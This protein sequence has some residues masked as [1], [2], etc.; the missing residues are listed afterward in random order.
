MNLETQFLYFLIAEAFSYLTGQKYFKIEF[1]D[2][3][4][5]KSI[6]WRSA[7]FYY[8]RGLWRPHTRNCIIMQE[9]INRFP[10][11]LIVFLNS[12]A[13]QLNLKDV[14]ELNRNLRWL[15]E[16]K[17]PIKLLLVIINARQHNHCYTVWYSLKNLLLIRGRGGG[18][19][20]L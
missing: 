14:I 19:V 8:N 13:H 1:P 11:P 3:E 10:F 15:I 2:G 7:V 18:A 20:W 9:T 5:L 16:I 17:F 4:Q 6:T 12:K